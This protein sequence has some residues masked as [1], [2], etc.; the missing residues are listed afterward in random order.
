M[1]AVRTKS[2]T[3]KHDSRPHYE[4]T[5]AYGTK[6]SSF[7]TIVVYITQHKDQLGLT[8]STFYS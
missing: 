2:S 8:N 1:Y 6:V 3:Q 5:E 7:S 4:I